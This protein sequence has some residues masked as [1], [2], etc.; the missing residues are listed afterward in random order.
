MIRNIGKITLA[1]LLA[2]IVV[3]VPLKSAAQD[4]NKPATPATPSTPAETPKAKGTQIR[5]TLSE[6]DKTAKTF[7]VETR[8]GKKS[9]YEVSS[10][11]KFFKRD[12]DTE[13]SA[14]LE[15]GVVGQPV[16]GSYTK[17]DDGKMTAKNVYWGGGPRSKKKTEGDATSPTPAPK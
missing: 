6:I 17:A 12:S 1:G 13:K 15:D 16:T 3:G 2:A 14:T 4:Q 8:S 10:D 5:G 9:V 11:T 7:T